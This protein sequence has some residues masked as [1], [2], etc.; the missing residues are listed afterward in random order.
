MSP[1]A[2]EMD[3]D[4]EGERVK[5][6]FLEI[7]LNTPA[8]DWKLA[9]ESEGIKILSRKSEELKGT[10]YKSEVIFPASPE[11]VFAMVCP[12]KPYRIQWDDLLDKLETAK[13]IGHNRFL[14]YHVTHPAAKGIVS[15]RDS[16]DVVTVGETDKYFFVSAGGVDHPDYGVNPKFVRTFQ[17]P[18]GYLI[19]KIS[20]NP[21]ECKFI[22]LLHTDLSMGAVMSF[23]VDKVKPTLMIQKITALR[24]GLETMTVDEKDLDQGTETY[25]NGM[26]TKEKKDMALENMQQPQPADT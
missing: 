1:A 18:A 6:R 21:N 25:M 15:A 4:Q 9:K 26:E 19:E 16:L 24:K 13:K 12:V 10:M 2:T 8:E 11:R 14:I 3:Y 22:M 20:E 17:Y 7:V 5:E 23:M